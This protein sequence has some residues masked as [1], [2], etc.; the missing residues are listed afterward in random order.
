LDVPFMKN[1]LASCE[2]L[3]LEFWKILNPKIQELGPSACLHQ[4]RLYETPK[5]YVDYF[6]E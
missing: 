2:N 1:K 5:N 6:G 3:I 4:L